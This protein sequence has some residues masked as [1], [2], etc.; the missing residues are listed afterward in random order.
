MM[1]Y[2][3]VGTPETVHGFL[4]NFAASVDA[5]ELIIAHQSPLIADRLRSVG[6]TAQAMEIGAA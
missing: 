2:T 3:A 6:L 4:D 1:R 5:D